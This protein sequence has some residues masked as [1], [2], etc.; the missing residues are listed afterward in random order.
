MPDDLPESTPQPLAQLVT[1]DT[2]TAY[3]RA[4]AD[5]DDEQREA[6]ILRVE[7]GMSHEEIAHVIG[8]PSPN[9]ARMK[10]ARALMRL[11]ECM[12]EHRSG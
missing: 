3:E 10:V 7:L 5:L 4:L 1:L 11:A 6:V 8:A 9:A 2:L 12:H